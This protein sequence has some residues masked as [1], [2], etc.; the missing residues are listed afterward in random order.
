[1]AVK[2][3]HTSGIRGLNA[4]DANQVCRQLYVSGQWQKGPV[5]VRC[6]LTH[7]CPQLETEDVRRRVSVVGAAQR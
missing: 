5:T 3:Q 6:L 1:M 7:S 2:Q 4:L